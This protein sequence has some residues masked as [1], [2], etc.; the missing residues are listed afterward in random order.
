MADAVQEPATGSSSHESSKDK[1]I[2]ALD[3]VR[4]IAILLVL[5]SHFP[6]P[7]RW[8]YPFQS[9]GWCGVDLFFVLSGYLIT[10][11][12]YSSVNRPHYFRNFYIRRTLRIFPLYYAFLVLVIFILPRVVS[13]YYLGMETTQSPW[14][15]FL[16]YSNYADV[17]AAWA[18]FSLSPFWSLAVEEHFYLVWPTVVRVIPRNRLVLCAALVSLFALLSRL[19]IAAFQWGWLPAYCLTTSRADSLAIGAMVAVLERQRPEWLKRWI[20][21]ISGSTAAALVG[22]AK[23]RHNLDFN[24]WTM[25]TF[26]YSLLA[27]TFAGLV[28]LAGNTRGPISQFLGNRVL[29]IFGRYSYCLYVLHMFVLIVFTRWFAPRFFPALGWK[30]DAPLP[31]STLSLAEIG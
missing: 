19:A 25:T 10:G 6:A 14:A 23:W 18:P 2:P 24:D 31:L 3:G 17:F 15:S 12:L 30:A 9:V 21:V 28:W 29:V 4:G 13:R 5:L 1:H 7:F 20:L 22:I 16:Y 26:G 27:L 11:I 8:M